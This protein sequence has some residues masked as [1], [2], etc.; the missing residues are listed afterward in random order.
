MKCSTIGVEKY[1]NFPVRE[2]P[3]RPPKQFQD[4][5]SPTTI[6]H[7]SI[8]SIVWSLSVDLPPDKFLKKALSYS[9]HGLLLFVIM[10]ASIIRQLG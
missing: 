4:F 3:I 6:C 5:S 9:G 2:N 1:K 10:M 8:L 7:L